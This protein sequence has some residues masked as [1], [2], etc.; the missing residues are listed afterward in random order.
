[1]N[2]EER[3]NKQKQLIEN[4]G[5]KFDKEGYQPIAGRIIALLM[6]MDKELFTF[7]EIIEELQ[8]SKSSASNV[9]KNLEIRDVIEYITITGDRKKYYRI[10]KK[11]AIEIIEKVIYSLIETK[12]MF[13][14][15]LQLKSNKDSENSV[16]F[17]E[18]LGI[19]DLYVLHIEKFQKNYKTEK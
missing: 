7:D 8:I 14:D 10:K 6:V 11:N 18:L 3:K 13:E 1:M 15:I 17:K 5:I 4:I 2:E 16:F 9:L 19:I 12:N